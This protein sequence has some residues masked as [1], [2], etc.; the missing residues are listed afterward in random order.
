[1]LRRSDG[2][3][4]SM[5]GPSSEILNGGDQGARAGAASIAGLK[6]LEEEDDDRVDAKNAASRLASST[7]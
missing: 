3:D 2:L 4:R 6:S 5:S 7:F 1:M